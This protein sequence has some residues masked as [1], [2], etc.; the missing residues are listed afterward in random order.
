[1]HQQ[2]HRPERREFP[3]A[4]ETVQVRGTLR[5]NTPISF[6]IREIAPILSSFAERQPALTVEPGLNDRQANLIEEGWDL[7]IRIGSMGD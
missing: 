3:A 2:Y 5:F 6:G 1:M 4:A 7:V